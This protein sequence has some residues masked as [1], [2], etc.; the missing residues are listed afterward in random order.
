MTTKFNKIFVVS[1][2]VCIMYG[3][4][5]CKKENNTILKVRYGTSFGEYMGYCKKDIIITRDHIEFIKSGWVDTLKTKSFKDSIEGNKWSELT[6]KINIPKFNSLK[7]IIGCPDCANC[8]AEWI[9]IETMESKH[10]VTFASG[11]EPD[12]VKS[13]IETL[14]GYLNIFQN[15]N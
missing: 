5:T 15:C 10:K 14:R 1:G 8:G 9:E 11:N 2:N 13:Y 7:T 3:I 12:E 4:V 6:Q